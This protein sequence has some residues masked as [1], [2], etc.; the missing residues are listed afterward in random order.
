[1]SFTEAQLIE[2][3]K[4]LGASECS[5]ALGMSSWMSPLELYKSKKGEL[6]PIETTLPMLVGTALEPICIEMFERES[7][8]KVT[9]RQAVVVDPKKPWRRSSLDGRAS[10]G[11]LIEAKT[12]GDYRGWGEAGDEIPLPYLYN[13]H[14]SFLTV[15]DAKKAYFPVL[16]GGRTFRI[17][18]VIRNNDLCDLVDQG[19]SPFW[20]K[21]M[22]NI[23]PDPTTSTDVRLKY[24]KDHGITRTASVDQAKAV[25]ELKGMKSAAKV[26]NEKL[27]AAQMVVENIIG[28]AATL[29]AVDGSV[30]ATWKSQSRSE[31]TV[32]ASEFRVLRVK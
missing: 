21:V 6:P 18:E 25:S 26:L 4:Y 32:K 22:H 1:M 30:L 10:D 9:D 27:E 19:E 14:H 7:G 8:L 16:L 15:P 29:L 24:P 28:D 31:Y 12:S 11:S 23:M 2:R 3:R 20:E 13:I 5:A 17:F